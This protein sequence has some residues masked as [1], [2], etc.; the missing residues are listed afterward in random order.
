VR[1]CLVWWPLALVFSPGGDA[2]RKRGV[3][4]GG[5]AMKRNKYLRRIAFCLM[6]GC[7]ATSFTNATAG[8]TTITMVVEEDKGLFV[9]VMPV[10]FTVPSVSV[11]SAGIPF[12]VFAIPNQETVLIQSGPP[13]ELFNIYAAV[14][15]LPEPF[16]VQLS[17]DIFWFIAANTGTGI[18]PLPDGMVLQSASLGGVPATITPISSLASLPTSS[19]NDLSIAWDTSALTNTTGNFFLAEATLPNALLVPGPIVG[20]G[21][22]GLVM[23][24]GGLLVWW[25]RR[26]KIA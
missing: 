23:A 10:T 12:G 22:P 9:P 3:E 11:G 26:Q 15:E 5:S 13:F 17:I 8:A 21:L 19:A 14:I 25:R 7:G 20:A 16:N 4:M 6:M 1:D 18:G 24:C 2:V